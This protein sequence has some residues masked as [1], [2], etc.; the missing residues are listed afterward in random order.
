MTTE[1]AQEGVTKERGRGQVPTLGEALGGGGLGVGAPS[2]ASWGF[3]ASP[4]AL[5][6]TSSLAMLGIHPP[7]QDRWLEGAEFLVRIPTYFKPPSYVGRHQGQ[8]SG[9]K[10][11]R[12]PKREAA[13][14]RQILAR[15]SQ[16]TLKPRPRSWGFWAALVPPYEGTPLELG[17]HGSGLHKS[18]NWDGRRSIHRTAQSGT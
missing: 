15:E 14:Q 8:C 18:R 16:A 10:Q 12:R 7:A 4:A 1:C 17:R 5:T 6:L 13:E 11:E 3:E 2:L 9:R